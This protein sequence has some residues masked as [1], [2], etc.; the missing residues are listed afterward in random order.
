MYMCVH[1]CTCMYMYM[2]YMYIHVHVLKVAT[3]N[4]AQMYIQ[5]TSTNVHTC[6][7]IYIMLASLPIMLLNLFSALINLDLL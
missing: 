3:C 6:M 4:Y 5:Y 2:L 7:Y 1:T